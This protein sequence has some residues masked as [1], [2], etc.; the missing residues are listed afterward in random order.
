LTDRQLWERFTA[1]RDAAGDAAFAALVTRYGP[2]V[3]RV[4][5][6]FQKNGPALTCSGPPRRMER[7]RARPALA[8]R[9]VGVMIR[10]E[11]RCFVSNPFPRPEKEVS[12]GTAQREEGAQDHAGPQAGAE[13]QAPG[14]QAGGADRAAGH[15]QPQRDARVRSRRGCTVTRQPGAR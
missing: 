14:H 7:R 13:A 3:L 5:R 10:P 12:H 15:G 4:Y 2:M 6:E 11:E 1:R 9:A 8:A